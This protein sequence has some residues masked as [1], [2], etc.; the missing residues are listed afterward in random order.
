MEYI[1]NHALEKVKGVAGEERNRD[2]LFRICRKY[3]LTELLRHFVDE[4]GIH[5]LLRRMQRDSDQASS[6]MGLV[7]RYCILEAIHNAPIDKT[8]IRLTVKCGTKEVELTSSNTE[9]AS[10][11]IM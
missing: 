10:L 4:L 7:K 6:F 8:V 9:V 3:R 2:R 11:H 5:R 1:L